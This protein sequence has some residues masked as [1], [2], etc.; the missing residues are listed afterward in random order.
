MSVAEPKA[1]GR[2]IIA[3]T[4][5]IA[6]WLSVIPL[7]DWARWARP[8]WVAMVL[9]YW[10]IALPHRVGI[11]ASF[12]TGLALDLVEGAPLG[13]NALALGVVAYLALILYQRMRM[14]TAW[15]QAGIVFVLIGLNQLLCHW[16]Q[17]L[18]TK[19]VPTM[20]FLLPTLISALLW[21]TVMPLLR[22]MRRHFLV[23]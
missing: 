14:Y 17:T 9:I 16:V 10:V 8:E 20:L 21:P 22:K 2:G 19:V 3:V 5:V 7:P 18:M 15:Q 12:F 4:L 1:S 11:G 6:L 13:Q 23:T